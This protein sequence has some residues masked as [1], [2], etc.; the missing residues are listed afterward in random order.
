MVSEVMTAKVLAVGPGT[1]LETAAR[2]FAQKRVSGAPVV[3]ENGEVVGV[4]SL[5]DLSDPDRDRSDELGDG[6]YYS[7]QAGLAD[8]H[9][10]PTVRR[11]G[12]VADV[13]TPAVLSI[14]PHASIVDAGRKMVAMDVQRLVVVDDQQLLAGIVSVIDIVRGFVNAADVQL[15]D[16]SL[17]VDVDSAGITTPAAPPR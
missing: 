8:E 1:S 4:V 5:T 12:T 6:L 10:D 11:Q 2:L 13:M 16:G 3:E 14:A 9:G 17:C 15:D 7:L